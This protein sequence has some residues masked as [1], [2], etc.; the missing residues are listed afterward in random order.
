MKREPQLGLVLHETWTMTEPHDLRHLVEL[1]RI[2]EQAGVG[3]VL[4]GEHP[5]MGPNSCVNGPPLNPR[6]WLAAGN[7][8]S[9]YPHPANLPLLSAMAAVTS[10]VRLFAAGLL[11][12]LRPP[13]LVAKEIAT[14]DLIARG[15]LVVVPIVSWQREEYEGMGVDFSSRGAMLDEQF[16]IWQRL[17]TEGSPVSFEGDFYRFSDM[18]VEPAPYRPGGVELWTGGRSYAPWVLRRTARFASG[19][20]T[21][22]PPSVEDIRAL[23]D[24]MLAAGR[25]PSDLELGAV[26]PIK[27][28]VDATGLLD[29]D[30]TLARAPEFIERGIT[31]LFIKPSMFIDDV[32]DFEQF[33]RDAVRKLHSAVR[34]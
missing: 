14:L 2:A 21:V 30:E 25:D 19:I 20:F 17:W 18:Y 4:V 7:Q 24:A 22:Q 5:A 13:L 27:P 9:D 16:E 31:T 29:L 8:P 15:R 23:G 28:F 32:D 11:S 26:L 10:R 6:D 1:A 33:C 3:S 34:Q 12:V